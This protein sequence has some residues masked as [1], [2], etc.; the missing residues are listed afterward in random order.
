[1][2]SGCIYCVNIQAGWMQEYH[3]TYITNKVTLF[4]FFKALI[5]IQVP[6]GTWSCGPYAM[7]ETKRPLAFLKTKY[8]YECVFK[9]GSVI[10]RSEVTVIG[11]IHD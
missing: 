3:S 5:T 2:F 7:T 11:T 10:Y 8:L 6:T 4:N 9:T 1:M